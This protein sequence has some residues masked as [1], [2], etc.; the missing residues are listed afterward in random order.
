MIILGVDP[1]YGRTGYAII[2]KTKSGEK[3]L[4]YGCI[5]TPA[6]EDYFKRLLALGEKI[7]KV[8]KKHKPDILAVEKIFFSKNQKTAIKVAEAKGIIT[9][10]AIKN[11]VNEIIEYAPNEVKT[12]ICGYGKAS[13]NQIK[14]MVGLILKISENIKPDDTIDAIALCLC[15]TNKNQY[16]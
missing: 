13:K 7:E 5:E 12:I 14:K 11:G 15:Y 3:L 10:V 9:Y 8:I 1:G 2:E 6:P 4:D 16:N